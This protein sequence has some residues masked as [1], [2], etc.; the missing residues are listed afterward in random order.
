MS[1][2]LAETKETQS[3]MIR[4]TLIGFLSLV[5][6]MGIGR[7]VFTPILPLMQADG[8]VSVTE[9]GW[10][11]AVHF[12]GYWI[13]AIS[14]SKLPFSPKRV[15]QAA[16]LL[17]SSSVLAMGL[18]DHFVPWLILRFFAGIL[19]AFTLVMVSSHYIETLSKAGK[20]GGQGFVFSG[21]GGGIAFSG[22][23]TL[24]IMVEGIG[25][26][27]SWIIFGVFS[28][29]VALLLCL[30]MKDEISNIPA[31]RKT[32]E[33]G[34]KTPLN[35][36]NIT[37]Y[38]AMGIGYI[39]PATYLPLMAKEI[40][41]DP[42]V[43]GWSW[44]IFGAAAFLSTLIAARL[45]RWFS[46]AMIWRVSQWIM[47][48]G[49]VLPVLFPNIISILLAGLAVG[50]TFMIIT[51][52]G[53]K[54][55]HRTVVPSDVVRH[56]ALLTAAFAGGQMIGPLFASVLFSFTGSFDASLIVT[57]VILLTSGFLVRR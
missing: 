22:F 31:T 57:A 41:S 16:L 17:V 55:A 39:I 53:M 36:R 37:A 54:E 51:M 45:Q 9:G 19:S 2:D 30:F 26:S 11:A 20:T 44:P 13:G 24:L 8:L 29:S 1:L 27:Q 35:F 23:L 46:N 33:A 50:G 15:L 32:A 5:V 6:A 43:F 48:G 4:V 38:G 12:L 21:V 34:E 42:L 18:I 47:A 7:F 14:A 10:I 25:S 52:M 56:I 40:I 28:L 49:V 3:G